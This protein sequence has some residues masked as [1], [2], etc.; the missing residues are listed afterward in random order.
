MVTMDS[1][2]AAMPAP[3]L[4]CVQGSVPTQPPFLTMNYIIALQGLY[5]P[6]P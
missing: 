4:V 6:R 2:G 1:A 3:L 5:P